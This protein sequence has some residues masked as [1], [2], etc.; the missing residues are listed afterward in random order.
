[1]ETT[2]EIR[3]EQRSDTETWYCVYKNNSWE[4]SFS[5]EIE[6][7]EY[8]NQCKAEITSG[9]PKIEIVKSEIINQK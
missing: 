4:N 3:Q 1:M 6:A 8:F 5:T 7:V 2:L 9:Y